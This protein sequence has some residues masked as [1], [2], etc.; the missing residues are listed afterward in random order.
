[1]ANVLIIKGF[2]IIKQNAK[3]PE[4]L[5]RSTFPTLLNITMS[6]HVHG[7]RTKEDTAKTWRV[8]PFVA[9]LCG[10]SKCKLAVMWRLHRNSCN[11]DGTYRSG[12][13]V[14]C[15]RMCEIK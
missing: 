5:A 12:R 9:R 13:Y 4:L 11:L 3:D 14:M 7:R 10:Q 15:A 1:M 2:V 6:L 8:V